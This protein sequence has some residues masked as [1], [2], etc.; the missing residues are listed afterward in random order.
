ML[1]PKKTQPLY[2]RP[3][4]VIGVVVLLLVIALVSSEVTGATHLFH[5]HGSAKITTTAS[6]STKGEGT[7][8]QSTKSADTPGG[9][10]APAPVPKS[11]SDDTKSSGSTSANLIDPSGVFVSAHHSV[12]ADAALSSACNTTVGATCRIEFTSSTTIKSLPTQPTDSGGAVYWNS[13]TPASIGLT[14]GTWHV[15]AI[16]ELGG[17]TATASDALD[18]EVR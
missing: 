8:T 4:L 15:K 7:S 5:S 16:A 2:K 11:T 17:K 1:Y 14:T 6:Q 9:E 13:W 10:P 3:L 18:L 12:P